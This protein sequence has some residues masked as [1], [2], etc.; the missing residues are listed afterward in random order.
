MPPQRG[1]RRLP[2][3]VIVAC[4]R[5]GLRLSDHVLVVSVA[6]QQVRWYRR[7]H[8]DTNPSPPIHG[9]YRLHRTLRASTSRFGIG[10]VRDSNRT[11]LGLHRVSRKIGDGWPVGTAFRARVPVGFTWK[12]LPTA[13]IAH[14]IL[15][16]EGLEPGFNQGGCV[17]TRSRFIYIHGLADEPTLGRPASHGCVHLAAN[18]LIPLHD[19]VPVE[20]LVWI[21][22][23]P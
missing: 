4:R 17:D 1:D 5:L 21:T 11:P 9:E 16:L 7:P 8:A 15:W 23:G 19:Q 12:G 2:A 10:Q 6:R 18:D 22:A 20:T 13:T 14:R 3:G